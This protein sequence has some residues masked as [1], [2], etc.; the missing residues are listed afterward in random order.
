LQVNQK[1]RDPL[2]AWYV[3]TGKEVVDEAVKLE[4][5]VPAVAQLLSSFGI[6]LM[7]FKQYV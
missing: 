4:G 7:E 5:R 2:R 1:V 3:K 6:V